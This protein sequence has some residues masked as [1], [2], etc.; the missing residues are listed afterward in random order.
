MGGV[1]ADKPALKNCRLAGPHPTHFGD[2]F[3]EYD[4]DGDILDDADARPTDDGESIL[5]E[6]D[7]HPTHFGDG[8]E[9]YDGDGNVQDDTVA[10]ASASTD[11]V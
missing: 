4:G 6:P 1:F 3:E 2:G 8:F 5:Q 7:Q 10:E 11:V 9:E